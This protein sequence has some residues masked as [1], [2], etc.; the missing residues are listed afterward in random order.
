[1]QSNSEF[2]DFIHPI[3]GQEITAIG[4]HYV[5]NKEGRLDVDSREVVYL[6]GYAVVDTSCCG[7]GGCAYAL[8]PGIVKEWK[9]KKDDDG[10]SVSQVEPIHDADEQQ[11]IRGLIQ[12]KEMVQQ[13][14]FNL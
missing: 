10:L 6:V 11:E 9:Y 4:G 13:V 5:F 12:K 1:M 14:T 8:V 7:M 2:Q 3:L